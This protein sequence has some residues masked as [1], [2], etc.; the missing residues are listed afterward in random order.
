MIANLYRRIVP[1]AWRERIYRLFLQKWLASG[2]ELKRRIHG[3]RAR[4]AFRRY[5]PAFQ[6]RKVLEVGGPSALFGSEGLLP[7]YAA[8]RTI[9]GCNF[10]S[11]TVW[12]GTI[13]DRKYRFAGRELGTQYIAEATAVSACTGAGVYDAVISSNCLE[14]VADPIRAVKDWVRVLKPGG[15]LLLAVPDKRAGFDRFRDDTS[16][17]HLLEDERRGTG[18]DDLSHLDEILEKHDFRLDPVAGGREAFER[19]AHRN[20]ENRCLHHHVFNPEVARQLC[21]YV[22]LDVVFRASA[23]DDHIVLGRKKAPQ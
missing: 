10:S 18:E 17:G 11:Q 13:A 3:R 4:R 20:R 16:F 14:H 8:G 5:L 21:E 19:R 12:E 9:D 1:P 23:W 7:V 6:D 22:G 2:R 15:W